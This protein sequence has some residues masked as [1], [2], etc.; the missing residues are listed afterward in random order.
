M[1]PDPANPFLAL[2]A[3]SDDALLEEAVRLAANEREST[4]ALIAAIAEIDARRLYRQEGFKSTY[5]YC[6]RVLKLS[7]HAA[8][9][10]IAAARKLREFPGILQRLKDGTLTLSNL[11]LLGP[12]LESHN[13][14]ELLQAAENRSKQE[15]EAIVSTLRPKGPTPEL[16]RLELH[17]SREAWEHL[18][19]LQ[20]L[21]RPSIGDGNPSRIFERAVALLL[22]NTE[23]RK[24]AKV[25][26]PH[27]PQ[28]PTPGSRHVPADVKR[29]VS[30]RDEGRCAF[31]GRTGRC[32][33][34]AGL[35]FH[36]V[37]AFAAGGVAT[38]DNIELRCRVHNKYEAEL[39]FGA[40]AVHRT[41]PGA[42]PTKGAAK[43][44]A[45]P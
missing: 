33:E 2:Y 11:T 35:E 39:D 5:T 28:P 3:L 20:E 17:I 42:S 18:L 15:V 22:A 43:T 19:R 32:T 23:A 9:D 41:R 12:F 16:Y 34:T 21:L 10:R 14:D 4:A 37:K 44:R 40:R 25:E 7:E 30:A 26:H 13:C 24:M 29:K 8:Y 1:P 31:V 45:G 27:A 38:V 6:R 36:H